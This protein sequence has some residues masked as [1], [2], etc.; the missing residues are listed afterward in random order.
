MGISDLHDLSES[1]KTL[2]DLLLLSSV[3]GFLKSCANGE[4]PRHMRAEGR[5]DFSS[6]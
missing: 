6:L 2:L 1:I 4:V 3:G 5:V